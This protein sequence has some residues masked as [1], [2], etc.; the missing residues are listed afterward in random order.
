[1]IADI[2]AR[3]RFSAEK[4]AKET[5][6]ESERMMIGLNC[7]EPGQSQAPHAHAGADKLYYVVAGR[8]RFVV[9]TSTV[10]AGSGD[11]VVCP[12]GEPHGIER[13]LERTTL[14]VAIAPWQRKEKV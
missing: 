3:A 11:L 6:H 9:G 14:L 4:M 12:A 10:E 13:A 7:L 1:M 5:L 2:A 8:A